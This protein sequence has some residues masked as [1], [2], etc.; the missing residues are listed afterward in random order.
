MTPLFLILIAAVILTSIWLNAV[1]SRIG[2]PAL[3]AFMLLGMVFANNGIWPVRFDNYSFAKETCT[4]ALV[5]IMFY[6]GFGTRWEAVKPVWKESVLLASAGV[7]VTAGLTGLF[8]HYALGWDWLESLLFGSV[9]GSTDA[10]SV[11]SILRSKR[12]GL[13][14]NSAPM[15]EMESGSNDPAAYML[16]AVFLSIM[17]GSASGG[18]I[19]WNVFAQLVFGAGCGVAIAKISALAF[20]KIHFQTK[21]FDSLFIFGIAMASYGI[22][23]LIGGNGYLSA[24]LVGVLLGNEEFKGKKALV[25]FFD[26][27]TGLMQMLIFF[28]LGLL[29]R[30]TLL[31]KAILPAFAI[32]LF[33]LLVARPAAVFGL[34]PP[35]RKYGVKQMAFISFVGLRGAASIVFAIMAM[36]DPAFIEHDIFNIVFMV[37]LLSIALQGSL[38]PWAARGLEM[39]DPGAD[40]MK[41]FNDYSDDTE[42][43]F[44][45][46][47][48]S[49]GSPWAGKAIKALGLPK[50]VLI[51][52]VIRG[53][54]HIQP[55]GNTVL[56]E[57][58]EVITLTHGFDDTS[59]SLFEKTVKENGR[60]AG[61]RIADIPGDGLI[62]LVRRRGKDI[63]PRGDTV[64][65]VGDRLV[66]LNLQHNPARF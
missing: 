64:L 50:N 2:I 39:V 19:A 56:Q 29:A 59:I 18:T 10:A 34:L 57:G 24:Y 61:M 32:F 4:I 55:N 42:M 8:C 20:K 52:L 28:L 5:F 15:L 1:S 45:R 37:V 16:T 63:I 38:I 9:M 54:G 13:K 65:K 7:M 47:P 33:M 48:I 58:D 41:T 27:I 40:V 46:I 30:P 53:E 21:G 3:L 43:N 66:I 62:V 12:L 60:R 23:S 44:G 26:G 22:P 31:H 11:F 49:K 14:N 35:F 6:G 17:N 25:N 51:A 36:V